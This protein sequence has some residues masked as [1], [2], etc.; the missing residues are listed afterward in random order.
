[1]RWGETH[2]L[3]G[4]TTSRSGD[5]VTKIIGMTS[6]TFDNTLSAAAPDVGA[7]KGLT[8]RLSTGDPAPD[9]V[10]P[11]STGLMVQ[12]SELRGRNVIIYFYPAANTPGCTL[13]ARDFRDVLSKLKHKDYVVLGISPDEPWQL[14]A[15]AAHE[16]LTFTLLADP[17]KKVLAEWGTYGLRKVYGRTLLSV[18]RSTFVVDVSGRISHAHFGVRPSGHVSRLLTELGI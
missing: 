15:F 14:A 2:C 10:L 17:G 5:S 3:T 13:Q 4:Q 6:G 1:M 18:I 16:K 7:G 11:D 9:F 12:L 8:R